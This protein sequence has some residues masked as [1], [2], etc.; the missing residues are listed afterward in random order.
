MVNQWR[1]K[2]MALRD[3]NPVRK[4]N[5]KRHFMNEKYEHDTVAMWKY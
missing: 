5:P 4:I 2:D 3:Q 1:A